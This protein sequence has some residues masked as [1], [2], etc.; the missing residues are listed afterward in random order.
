MILR[1]PRLAAQVPLS[2]V[3][4]SETG[5]LPSCWTVGQAIARNG[6]KVKDRD[7]RLTDAMQVTWCQFIDR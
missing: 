2:H 1:F 6:C 3:L 5:G 7:D 4:R